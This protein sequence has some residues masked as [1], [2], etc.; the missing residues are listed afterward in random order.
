[1]T[2]DIWLNLPVKDVAVSKKF[3]TDLGYT[4]N[5]GKDNETMACMTVSDKKFV[6]ML[7]A[8]YMFETFTQSDSTDTK[9]SAE[10]LVSLEVQT[11]EEV[12]EL[13]VKVTEA[14]GTVFAQPGVKMG[15]LYGM[16]F[17]D[18]DGHRWNVMYMD[19]SKMPK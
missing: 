19:W 1:M 14:G 13:A 9:Q 15:W 4:F 16:G 5:S 8:D 12:D 3:F 2:K 6:V 10:I 7:F 17:A 11:R 18:P